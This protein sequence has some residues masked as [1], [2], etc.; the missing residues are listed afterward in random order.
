VLYN[1]EEITAKELD[2][3]YMTD[4]VQAMGAT[5]NIN[6]V[7]VSAH[8]ADSG[9]GAIVNYLFV[10]DYS[11][12]I[13]QP[14]FNDRYFT[15]LE[16]ANPSLYWISQGTGGETSMYHVKTK[17]VRRSLQTCY[18]SLIKRMNEVLYNFIAFLSL[19]TLQLI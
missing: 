10:G 12:Q 7:F 4:L 18:D 2:P 16:A 15:S 14:D 13:N 17:H 5:L 9:N 3:L 6:P 11:A 8:I 19:I 1:F